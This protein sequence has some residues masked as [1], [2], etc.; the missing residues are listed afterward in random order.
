MKILTLIGNG[1][2]LGHG[3]NTRFDNFIESNK[4][5]FSE[6]YSVFED[7]DNSWNNIEKRFQ[8]M[9]LETM[10]NRSWADV[11]DI[12]DDI[13]QRYGLNEYGEVDYYNYE[14]DL[15]QEEMDRITELIKLLS[16][17]EKDF[18]EYL[19]KECSSERIKEKHA[20][21]PIENIL[22]TSDVI[23]FN[24]TSTIEELY[25]KK[26]IIHIHGKLEDSIVI[27]CCALDCAKES[28]VDFEY[29]SID[30]FEKSKY[31]LQEIMGYYEYDDEGNRYEKTFIKRFFDEVATSSKNRE[32]ELFSTL[33]E[34]SKDSLPLRKNVI[35]NLENTHYD[36]VYIIGHSLGEVDY[37]VLDAINKDAV[38]VCSYHTEKDQVEKEETMKALGWKY[39]F[40][41][42]SDLYRQ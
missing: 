20:F 37:S 4:C 27:G 14:S 21:S 30:S 16:D 6:K 34:K 17:F 9:L 26:D 38:F 33:D 2:D 11:V 5:V 35:S 8:D 10:R 36:K 31:G 12:V 19:Q 25:G 40:I 41:K 22:S 23:S 7:G 39:S 15:H 29:P 18:A 1:F 13:I 28:M 32:D 42:D 24:Y 3:F